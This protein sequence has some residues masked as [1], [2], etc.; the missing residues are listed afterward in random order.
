MRGM[1]TLSQDN[2][3]LLVVRDKV[4]RPPGKLWVS[5]SM[6]CDIFPLS[7]LTLLVGRQEGHPACKKL[8]VGLMVVMIWLELCLIR[9][10]LFQPT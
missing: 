8:D 2:Q 9:D 6:E 5:K 4:G 1:A 7:A 3:K 10:E